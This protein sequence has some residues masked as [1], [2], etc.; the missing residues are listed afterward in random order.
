MVLNTKAARLATSLCLV[1]ASTLLHAAEMTIPL[2]V[3]YDLL[4]Q[5]VARQVYTDPGG[6]ARVWRESDCRFLTLD[7]PEFAP[8]GDRLRFSTHGIGSLGADVLE[9]CLGPGQWRGYIE[10]LMEAEITPEWQLK[11]KIVE[12]SL[13]DEQWNKGLLSGLLWEV[14]KGF[15]HPKLTALSIDLAPPR[16]E[17][18]SLLKVWVPSSAALEIKAILDSA[19]PKNVEVREHGL[20]VSLAMNVPDRYVRPAPPPTHPEPPLSPMEIQTYQQAFERWDAFLVFVVK[21]FGGDLVDP[22]IRGKLFDLLL[23]SRYQVLPLLAGLYPRSQG[24]PVRR[25]FVQTWK[26]LHEIVQ[27]STQRGLSGD[28]LLR[29]VGFI[30]AG[31]AL[32]T[33]ERAA[34]GLGIE[35]S[36][37]GLRRLARML[38]PEAIEDPLHYDLELDPGLRALFG[39]PPEIPIE[40]APEPVPESAIDWMSAAY[41]AGAEDTGLTTLK[42]RLDRW[43]PETS[44]L[45]RYVAV[46][47]QL[48]EHITGTALQGSALDAGYQTIYPAMMQAT[49]LK[50]SCWR[51]FVRKKNQ[52]TYLTS[53][54]GS[55]GL[56]QINPRVWRGFYSVQQ[57]KWNTHYNGRAGAE[58]LMQY[59]KR[60]GIEEAKQTGQLENAARAAYAVYNAGP[61][62]AKRY[63]AK[64]STAREKKV[65]DAFWGMY[66]G[67]A[68]HGEPDLQECKLITHSGTTPHGLSTPFL[69]LH[70]RTERAGRSAVAV[71]TGPKLWTRA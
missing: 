19:F 36:A 54:T 48:L 44:E 58:I 49:A 15:V 2:T 40:A 59:F 69:A 8:E 65:D 38:R 5:E 13:Y 6:I 41:A 23:A 25:L 21:G 45:D 30:Q 7:R 34:P 18:L 32:V 67:F 51:Q 17:V 11:L 66:R 63:R 70:E 64:H 61:A 42:K 22:A 55:L 35:I 29:Y 37:D 62:E 47:K 27:E 3:H 31:D 10:S 43:V 26:G 14:T 57:L 52:V 28:K 20:V 16:D 4:T 50:E 60:Y 39:L 71:E 33:L 1:A 53:P 12:S 68:N 9:T 56:M 24:D 46:M